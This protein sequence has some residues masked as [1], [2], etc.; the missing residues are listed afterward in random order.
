[1]RLLFRELATY[2]TIGLMAIIAVA[3]LFCATAT[4]W[5]SSYFEKFIRVSRVFYN[6]VRMHW[7]A[8]LLALSI[9]AKTAIRWFSKVN[10]QTSL[11]RDHRLLSA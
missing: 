1:M 4:L 7:L 8:S 2:H 9:I 6:L 5:F 11:W 3:Q 10:L